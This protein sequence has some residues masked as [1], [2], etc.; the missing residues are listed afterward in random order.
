MLLSPCCKIQ[1]TALACFMKVGEFKH[2][3]DSAWKQIRSKP[4]NDSNVLSLIAFLS[5]LISIDVLYFAT[6]SVQSIHS[7]S[8]LG[9]PW[10]AVKKLCQAEL[11]MPSN[12]HVDWRKSANGGSPPF[13]DKCVH[14]MQGRKSCSRWKTE[15]CTTFGLRQ[16]K[17]ENWEETSLLRTSQQTLK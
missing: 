11:N 13:P 1:V 2:V 3:E 8:L 10:K 12:F 14:N 17:N 7:V 9:D 5:M 15:V 6:I 4:R 16:Q